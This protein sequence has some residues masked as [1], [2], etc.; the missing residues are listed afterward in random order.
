MGVDAEDVRYFHVLAQAGTLVRAGEELGVD[1][2]TVSRRVQRL[3]HALD[4][5]LFT[6][7]RSGWAINSNG[8]RLLPAA[9]MVALGSDAFST[10]DPTR[11]G[12]EEWTILSPDGF[13]ASVLTPASA[14]LLATE[15][16]AL[17]ILSAPSLA[18][19]EG[20]AFDVAIVRSQPSSSTVRARRLADYEIGVF[21]HRDYLHRHRPITEPAD[22]DGHV[23][24]WYADDPI[25]GVPEFEALRPQL[26]TEIR[27]QSNNLNVHEQAALSGVGLAIMPTYTA[28]RHESLVRVL[29]EAI[30]FRGH[31]WAVVPTTQLRERTT[32]RVLD[33]LTAAVA[34]AGLERTEL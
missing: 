15:A 25:A 27:L 20:N 4:Q 16:V 3:E 30:G 31:Y 22:L 19:R 8:E 6:R 21:A 28:A 34:A 2:T 1:H 7:T 9:R 18:S 17:H 13:A 24:A 26:P 10:G 14:Q 32:Q 11:L 5:R 12:P 29:P 23:L 33:F